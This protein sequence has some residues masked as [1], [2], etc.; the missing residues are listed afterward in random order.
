M[1]QTFIHK[2]VSFANIFLFTEINIFFFFYLKYYARIFLLMDYILANLKQVVS[3]LFNINSFFFSF[4]FFRKASIALNLKVIKL[5]VKFTGFIL[6]KD[7]ID[8]SLEFQA[9]KRKNE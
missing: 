8:C 1:R 7:K 3:N 9:L 4:F 5:R 6:L 2:K